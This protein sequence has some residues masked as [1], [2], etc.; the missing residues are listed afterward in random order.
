M[1][2]PTAKFPSF[3]SMVS[4]NVAAQ[5][6]QGGGDAAASV[7]AT[8]QPAPPSTQPQAPTQPAQQTPTQPTQSQATTTQPAAAS[9]SN[10]VT[11]A[12]QSA[13]ST[14]FVSSLRAKGFDVPEGLD[15]SA[16]LDL[17]V[18]QIDE[19]NRIADQIAAGKAP[20]M[21][22]RPAP[23]QPTQPA[24]PAQQPTPQANQNNE[25]ALPA[26]PAVDD[27]ASPGSAA[28]D[29]PKLSEEARLFAA[30]GLLK[31]GPNGWVADNPA[32]QAL[33]DEHTRLDAYRQERAYKLLDNTDEFISPYVQ[34]MLDAR[35]KPLQ[36]QVEKLVAQLESQ[37]NLT[38][39]SEVDQWIEQNA[40]A[41]FVDG[42]RD[43]LSPYAQQFNAAASEIDSMAR[44]FGQ[45]LSKAELHNRTLRQL[46]KLGI[47]PEAG[48][49]SQ[50]TQAS[51]AQLEQRQPFL[52][53]A[54]NTPQQ[55]GHNRLTE[56]TAATQPT[57]TPHLPTGPGGVP[58]LARL[59]A[60]RRSGQV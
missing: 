37:A 56:Y 18:Q 42:D 10:S 30:N 15:D 20:G 21:D 4:N 1:T 45:E 11:P 43:Q 46:A 53:M 33:A 49:Q 27:S 39:E 12:A 54:A 16:A 41:L 5:S 55:N 24:K 14:S 17:V 28:G 52:Q 48:Q 32:F 6:Q 29:P 51:Q 2:E 22:S 40:N 8:S 26:Q 7:P 59:I 13:T 3:T 31:R 60:M 23:G 47:A 38:R 9:T 58:S 34:K 25:N 50:P 57:G 35:T 44:E 19:A 36:E